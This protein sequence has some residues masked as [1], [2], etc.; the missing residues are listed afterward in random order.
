[1]A[2]TIFIRTSLIGG[3]SS[4]LDGIDGA[5]LLQGD[6]AW[7]FASGTV[8]TYALEALSGLPQT[9]PGVIAPV[10]NA[11]LKRWILQSYYSTDAGAGDV[12]GPAST[13][14][15]RIPAWSATLKTLVDGYTL[16]IDPTLAGDSDTAI[17]SQKAVKAYVDKITKIVIVQVIA[18]ST[19]LTVG[20]GVAYVTVPEDLDGMNLVSAAAHVYTPSSS[21]AVTV[22]IHN[23][24]GG[25]DMLS[26][27]ITIDENEKDSATAEAPAVIDTDH[28][29]VAVGDEIRIDVTAAGTGAKGFEIRLGFRL[30]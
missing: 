12:I 23:A 30:P 14:E 29:A 25:N 15:G 16:D 13:T 9:S 19:P 3:T 10:T 5:A 7:I 17:A 2:K 22:Q 26:T 4:S 1:M 27:A 21:G 6:V 11:G 20:T 8:S 28:D 24:T 18:P